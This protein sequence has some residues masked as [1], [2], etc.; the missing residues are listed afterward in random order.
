MQTKLSIIKGNLPQHINELFEMITYNKINIIKTH[1]NTLP[2]HGFIIHTI[3]LKKKKK[4][5]V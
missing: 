1:I 2:I 4:N 3:L 5:A